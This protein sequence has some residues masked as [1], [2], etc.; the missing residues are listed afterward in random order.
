MNDYCAVVMAGGGGTRFWPRSRQTTP[1]QF[2]PIVGET[3]L[4][5][6]TVARLGLTCPPDSIRIITNERQVA[7]TRGCLPDLPAENIIA[8]PQARNTAP[9][10]G[11]AALLCQARTGADPV[12]GVFPADAYIT[13]DEAFVQTTAQ[14]V[15]LA[16]EDGVI[17]T[18]GVPPAFPAT[19]YGYIQCGPPRPGGEGWQVARFTEKPDAATA[20]AFL[21]AGGYFWNAG[22]FF[23]RAST[24]LAELA[25]QQPAIH[26]ALEALRPAL[27]TAGEAAAL[28][29]AYAAMPAISFDY[30]VMENAADV[31]VVE[32]TFSWDD[33]G[34]WAA[35]ARHGTADGAGNVTRGDVLILDGKNNTVE[36]ERTVA[37]LGV[38]D[39]IVVETADALLVCH[40]DR[41]EEVKRVVETL[42]TQGR[43]SLL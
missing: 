31:Q 29:S 14:A 20:Q 39:L 15:G 34:S 33:L 11:L 37:L 27:G 17:V 40:R 22:I 2:L 9:C 42:R 8:E 7:G 30:A 16:G 13:P 23:F 5:T 10:V 28:E 6:A 12:V 35:V 24:V 43:E 41:A 26:E 3:P 18:V 4:L 19:G 1:K 21:A 38:E 36:A 32:A 25:R